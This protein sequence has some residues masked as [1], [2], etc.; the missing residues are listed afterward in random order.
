MEDF[1]LEGPGRTGK[2]LPSRAWAD[3]DVMGPLE[4]SVKV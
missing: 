4:G 3:S 1:R 2:T